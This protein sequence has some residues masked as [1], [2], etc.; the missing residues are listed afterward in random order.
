MKE[1]KE[2]AFWALNTVQPEGLRVVRRQHK[3]LEELREAGMTGS[4][5]GE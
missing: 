2:W 5:E 4:G 3:M 1:D